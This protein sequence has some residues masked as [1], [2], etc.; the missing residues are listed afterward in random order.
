MKNYLNNKSFLQKIC[1]QI[2]SSRNIR[3]ISYTKENEPIESIEGKAISGSINIDG[4]SSTRRSCSL[5][6]LTENLDIHD[7]YWSLTTRFSVELGLENT[8]DQ[9]IN[10]KIIWFPMGYYVISSFSISLST[11]GA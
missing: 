11:T 8:T 2:N 1:K 10:E 6:L 9:Y 3:I 5:T 4:N 7:F